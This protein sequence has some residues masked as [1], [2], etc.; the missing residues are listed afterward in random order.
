MC[1]SHSTDFREFLLVFECFEQ[2]REQMDKKRLLRFR[3]ARR[4]LF[5]Q[6]HDLPWR[7]RRRLDRHTPNLLVPARLYAGDDIVQG[8]YMSRTVY[9]C[10]CVKSDL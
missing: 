2:I 3:G 10:T 7:Q 4:G 6:G 1:K 5:S 8:S 9:K